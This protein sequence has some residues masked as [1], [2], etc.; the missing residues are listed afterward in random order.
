M[1]QGKT[2]LAVRR[3]SR[4]WDASAAGTSGMSRSFDFCAITKSSQLRQQ[5]KTARERVL[6]APKTPAM[7]RSDRPVRMANDSATVT[8]RTW[9]SPYPA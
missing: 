5:S 8:V 9:P 4:L 2:P 1:E 6:P 3:W 7:Y